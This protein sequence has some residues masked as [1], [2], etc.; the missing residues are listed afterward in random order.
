[1]GERLEKPD[2]FSFEGFRYVIDKAKP[3]QVDLLGGE[4]T[5]WKP[6]KRAIGYCRDRDIPVYLFSN[7]SVVDKPLAKFLFESGCNVTGKLNVGGTS[8]EEIQMQKEL[9]GGTEKQVYQ[10]LRGIDNLLD[11]GFSGP[12][13]ALEN[14]LRP[15]NIAYAAGFVRFCKARDIRPDLEVPSCSGDALRNYGEKIPTV[16]QLVSLVREIEPLLGNTLVPPHFTGPCTYYKKVLYFRPNGDIQ[17]CSGRQVVIGDWTKPDGIIS[18][19]GSKI[20]QT[21]RNLQ[22]YQVSGKCGECDTWDYCCGG[23]RATVENLGNPLGSYPLCWRD[24]K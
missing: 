15:K 9:I 4:P 8:S 1:M 11:A 22:K 2:E 13:F 19:I 12:R 10:M 21:R 16:S 3:G 17:P 7:L 24:G 5:L 20:V 14:L 18:A 23:C 6:L